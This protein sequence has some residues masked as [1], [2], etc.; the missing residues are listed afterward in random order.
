MMHT[1][2]GGG[3]ESFS[4]VLQETCILDR[5]LAVLGSSEIRVFT[6]VAGSLALCLRRIFIATD[7]CVF[8]HSTN[9]SVCHSVII[10]ITDTFE[11]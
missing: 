8:V 3:I 4:R 1:S 5:R 10:I 6:L 9:A 11:Y 2:S 7:K